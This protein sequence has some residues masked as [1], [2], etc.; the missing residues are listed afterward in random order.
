MCYAVG[1]HV[2]PAEHGCVMQTKGLEKNVQQLH[3][4]TNIEDDKVGN[5]DIGK[6]EAQANDKGTEELKVVDRVVVG[7]EVYLPSAEFQSGP[8]GLVAL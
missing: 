7:N 2:S 8:E 4:P 3:Y 1:V 5:P 6:T